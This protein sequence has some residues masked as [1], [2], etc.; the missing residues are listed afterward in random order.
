MD[1]L[2]SVFFI[3]LALGA[4]VGF[5]AGLLGIGGGLI[6]V[7]ALL[8]ILPS[9]GVTSA[10]LP[11]IAIATSLA[12]IILTSISSTRAHHKRGNIPWHLFKPMLPGLVIGALA[13]GFIAEQIPADTLQQGFA[14][15]V[16]LMTIQMAYPVKT[17]SN[18]QLPNP[19]VLFVVSAFVAVL[20][21]LT[22]IGGGILIVPFLTFYG[23]QM[24]YAVGFS[25]AM[26]FLI[27]IS[28]SFGYIIA[29]MNATELPYG[30]VGFIYLPALFG[31]IITS[32][33]MAPVGVKA[34]S[35]WPT[36]VLKKIFALFLLCVGLKLM[37]T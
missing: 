6:V 31:L 22:G 1:S 4:F 37:L 24:R 25:A 30:T 20:A 29:G 16:I 27:S 32:V 15:F 7:P 2:L 23:L 21:G 8:Y 17:E 36:P 11:H 12:A 3:C 9:V 13:S 14:I 26:G 18:R 5:M 34:A 35:T 19:A 28:G 10:Q 33:L